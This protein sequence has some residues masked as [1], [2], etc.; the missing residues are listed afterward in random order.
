MATVMQKSYLVKGAV[1]GAR[2]DSCT[3]D[4][5]DCNPCRCG[6]SVRGDQ[7]NYPFWRVSGFHIEAGLIQ[8]IDV[9]HLT[10][11]SLTQPVVEGEND[12]WQEVILV[13]SAASMLQVVALLNVF[14]HQLD[15][16]PAEVAPL[17]QTSR[18]VYRAHL[19][20]HMS[21]DNKLTL[22]ATFSPDPQSLV[23]SPDGQAS[24]Q[25]RAWNYQGL[26]ALRDTFTYQKD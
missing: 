21:P 24:Q 1:F 6:D 14:E 25:A 15:S 5:C 9:S 18:A 13:D 16:V 2:G 12:R 20:Y 3:C 26:M 10:I 7:P 23:C 4:P 22:D 17:P 11:L 19:S 8:G